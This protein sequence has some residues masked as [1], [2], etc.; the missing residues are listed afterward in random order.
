MFISHV[1]KRLRDEPG[2]PRLDLPAFKNK[3]VEANARR[4]LTLSRADLVQLMDPGDVAESETHYLNAV[5]HLILVDRKQ[6]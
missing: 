5:F 3:L 4:L 6:P 2:F 1:W